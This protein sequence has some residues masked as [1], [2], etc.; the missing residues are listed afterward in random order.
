MDEEKTFRINTKLRISHHVTYCSRFSVQVRYLY[1]CSVPAP[2]LFISNF[3]YNCSS[4]LE[5]PTNASLKFTNTCEG[6]I[7]YVLLICCLD[8]SSYKNENR[9]HLELAKFTA[10]RKPEGNSK[11]WRSGINCI[12]SWV[13]YGILTATK[14]FL[15]LRMVPAVPWLSYLPPQCTL[16]NKNLPY[17]ISRDVDRQRVDVDPN[18]DSTFCLALLF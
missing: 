3:K 12:S 18:P 5:G 10:L 14:A 15:F 16:I 17:L 7:V 8:P 1:Y 2:Y 13:M 6:K 11:S 9:V 4:Q